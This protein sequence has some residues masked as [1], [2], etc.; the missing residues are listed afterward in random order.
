MACSLS[1]QFTRLKNWGNH[2]TATGHEI[3]D[4]IAFTARKLRLM[5]AGTQFA[6]SLL[7]NY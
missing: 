5:N 1:V 2:S 4:H 3:D 7:F 6:F